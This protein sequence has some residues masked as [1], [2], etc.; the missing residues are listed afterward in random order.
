MNFKIS[1]FVPIDYATGATCD[2]PNIAKSDV[3]PIV[4]LRKTKK[5]SAEDI[6]SYIVGSSAAFSFIPAKTNDPLGLTNPNGSAVVLD[7][8]DLVNPTRNST[9]SYYSPNRTV[10]VPPPCIVGDKIVHA[11]LVKFKVYGELR[12]GNGTVR[13]QARRKAADGWP[14]NNLFLC[15][16]EAAGYDGYV[17]S[18]APAGQY[19]IYESSTEIV[20][21]DTTATDLR[22]Q[23]R[24]I[25]P[26]TT[27]LLAGPVVYKVTAYLIGYFVA[28]PNAL[29][30]IVPPGPP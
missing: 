18:T 29:S 25:D 27:P 16:A 15:E 1:Q 12:R 10:I 2:N 13:V 19:P 22:F 9:F 11:C 8:V 24:F 4:N 5:I 21:L 20:Y 23:W 26:S 17:G 14:A 7:S 28:D 3:L 6:S 30:P